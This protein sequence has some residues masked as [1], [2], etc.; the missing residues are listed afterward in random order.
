[1][2]E[3]VH[4]FFFPTPLTLLMSVI[5]ALRQ[6][7][8]SFMAYTPVFLKQALIPYADHRLKDYIYVHLYLIKLYIAIIFIFI[9]WIHL[10]Q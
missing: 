7:K 1:M 10:S 9:C 2:I 4:L 5:L 8:V 3:N 6:S